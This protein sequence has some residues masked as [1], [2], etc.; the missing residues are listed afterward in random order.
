MTLGNSRYKNPSSLCASPVSGFITITSFSPGV[1]SGR[2]IFICPEI[3]ETT[4]ASFCSI[5]TL[6]PC[7]KF[8]PNIATSIPP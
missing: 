6:A 7:S 5:K 4:S 3:T 1:P 8:S 2:I